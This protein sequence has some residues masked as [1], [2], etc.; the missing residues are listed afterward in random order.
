MHVHTNQ[1]KKLTM[2]FCNYYFINK[3]I[4]TCL[5]ATDINMKTQNK[6]RVTK[7]T[8]KTAAKNIKQSF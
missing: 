1:N 3:I 6:L 4:K 8:T 7:S 2:I 5:N